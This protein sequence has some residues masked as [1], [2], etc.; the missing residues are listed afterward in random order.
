MIK[1]VYSVNMARIEQTIL[2]VT[3]ITILHTESPR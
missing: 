2:R 3:A 1:L